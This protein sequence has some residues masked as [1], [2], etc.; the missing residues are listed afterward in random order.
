MNKIN[1][2][3]SLPTSKRKVEKRS[4]S[5]TEENIRISRLYDIDYFDGSRDY[6]YGGYSYDGRWVPVSKDIVN[7]F[8]LKKGSKILDVGCA[9][10]FLIYDL[11]N[12]GM[13]VYGLDVS[14]YA[15]KN[16]VEGISDHI[17]I[18]DAKKLPYKND[19]F[20]L[21]LSIN[22][23]HNLEKKECEETI[24]ELSR[25]VKNKKNVFIQVDSYETK[26]EK[27]LFESWVLTAK[28][29]DYTYEWEK[30]FNKCNYQG[31]YFWT[32]IK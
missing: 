29:H 10:G 28:Y 9:K 5:K 19:Y 21:V 4:S 24:K 27:E 23:I 3:K 25:V 12:L 15:K 31:Y 2:L 22:T 14:E 17:T 32:I 16:S 20:D 26:E 1:L 18:G 30:L 7:F 13:N 8:D 6:G 11:K